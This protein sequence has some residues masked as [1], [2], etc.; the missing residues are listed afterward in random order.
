MELS[1]DVRSKL[2]LEH[3]YQEH[4]NVWR[5]FGATIERNGSMIE[6]STCDMTKDSA[7]ALALVLLH[8]ADEIEEDM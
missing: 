3:T 1:E 2:L 8:L 5:C 6:V 4:T 7:R